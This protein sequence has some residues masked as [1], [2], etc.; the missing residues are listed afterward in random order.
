L[1]T[2]QIANMELGN[3]FWK[4][5]NRSLHVLTRKHRKNLFW[6]Y[7]SLF[8]FCFL[9]TAGG[10]VLVS[11][12]FLALIKRN[13]P[14][15]IGYYYATFEY[16]DEFTYEYIG[17]NSIYYTNPFHF[18]AIVFRSKNSQKKAKLISSKNAKW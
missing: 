11:F 5:K 12:I 10:N 16:T 3:Q 7:K 14:R 2:Y 17:E 13:D 8:L 1:Q 18:N 9:W 6:F 15:Y 4:K